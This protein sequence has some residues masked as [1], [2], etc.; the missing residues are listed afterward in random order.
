MT[1]K[2]KAKDLFER[3]NKFSSNNIP[4]YEKYNN[5]DSAIRIAKYSAKQCSIIAVDEILKYQP[6]DVYSV[7]RSNHVNKYWQQVK[8]EIEKI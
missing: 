8:Q 5:T 2:E 3:F 4:D 7:F 6:Y 1:P